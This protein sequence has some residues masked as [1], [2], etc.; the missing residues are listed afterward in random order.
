[1]INPAAIEQAKL[2]ANNIARPEESKIYK[3]TIPSVTFNGFNTQLVSLGRVNDALIDQHEWDDI[4]SFYK[5][6]LTMGIYKKILIKKTM[7]IGAILI[8][9]VSQQVEIRRMIAE[10]IDVTPFEQEILQDGFSLRDWV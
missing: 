2:C 8:G 1:G 7:L 3:G 5:V 4:H 6:D 9:D 10:G